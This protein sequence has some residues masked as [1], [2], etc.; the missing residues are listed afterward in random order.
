[1]NKT[2]NTNVFPVKTSNTG[3]SSRFFDKTSPKKMPLR[4]TLRQ[5]LAIASRITRAV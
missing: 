2:H 3:Y 1:M 4:E 5:T